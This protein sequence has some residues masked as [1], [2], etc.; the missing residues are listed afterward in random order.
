M[1]DD[2]KYK[3]HWSDYS[4]REKIFLMFH[5][6]YY[7]GINNAN[8]GETLKFYRLLK[9]NIDKVFRY[10]EE[11]F[12]NGIHGPYHIIESI[13]NNKEVDLSVPKIMRDESKFVKQLNKTYN[14]VK[15][16]RKI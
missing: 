16:H 4:K 13:R 11:D 14:G 12:Y 3:N 9:E 10:A 7:Y 5:W 2:I 15:K 1:F 8:V 6:F